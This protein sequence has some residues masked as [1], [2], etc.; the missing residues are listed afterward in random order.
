MAS[1]FQRVAAFHREHPRAWTWHATMVMAGLSL[2]VGLGTVFY[3]GLLNPQF[4]AM[5]FFVTIGVAA[6]Y[7]PGVVLGVAAIGVRRGWLRWVRAGVAAAIV[8]GVLALGA[9]AGHLWL[10]PVSLL[11]V[12]GGLFWATGDFY[13]AWRLKRSLPWVAADAEGKRGFA[14][15]VAE[16]EAA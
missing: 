15:E 6:L 13:V 8:Q 7:V 16:A 10:G 12:L 11:L 4:R 3:D 9:V 2:V 1:L 14:I 5:V